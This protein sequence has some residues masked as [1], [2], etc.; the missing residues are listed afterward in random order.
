[1]VCAALVDPCDGA[2]LSQACYLPDRSAAA[3]EPPELTVGVARDDG[4]WWLTV[5]TRRFARWVHID[6]IAFRA[7]HDWFHLAPGSQRRV[8]LLPDHGPKGGG[9]EGAQGVGLAQA[10]PIPMGEVHALNARRAIAYSAPGA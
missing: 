9:R 10:D 6:D 1:M 8:K 5:S 2:L 7:E 4:D 3:L